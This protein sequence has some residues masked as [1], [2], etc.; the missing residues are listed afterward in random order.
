MMPV[1]R[2]RDG[3]GTLRK[4][5][6]MI[7]NCVALLSAGK[8]ILIFGEGNHNYQW[9]LRDLQKGFARIALAAE[10][11]NSWKLGVKIVPVGIQYDSHNDFRS[12]ALVTFGQPIVV[13]TFCKPAT[14]SNVDLLLNETA[15]K[16]KS[17]ILHINPDQYEAKASYLTS[18]RIVKKDLVEQ[19]N[20]DQAMVDQDLSPEG[21][22][23][24]AEKSFTK[25]FNPIFLYHYVN[26]LLPHLIIRWV[27]RNKVSDPQ[28]TGSL[29]YALG[30]VL[31]PVFYVF[32][33]VLCFLLT[34]SE[35]IS[36][37]YLLSLPISV[38]L[39][40]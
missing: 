20:S 21:I 4:N 30:M 11:K 9:Y 2:F 37:L 6:A 25:W 14:P 3:F 24:N 26:H 17:L 5:D 7:E 39:R 8:S 15:T 18:H 36:L 32:Q 13:N 12:R 22:P 19:L 1:Y 40:R 28:F 34:G 29:K 38:I 31:T 10:E 35:M 16:L 23:V 27:L 33:T